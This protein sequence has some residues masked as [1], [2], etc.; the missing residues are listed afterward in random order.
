MRECF[1]IGGGNSVQESIDSG[2]WE[3]LKGKDIWSVNYAFLTMPY[4]PTRE[5]WL[6]LF[7]FKNNIDK[8]QNLY[9][10]GV[11]CYTKQNNKYSLI[12]EIKTY[13]VSRDI[14]DV[15]GKMYSGGMG[16]SGFFA[17]HLAVEEKYDRIFLFGYDFGSITNDKKTHYYQDKISVMS[18]GVGKPE[19]YR[20]QNSSIKKEV[21]DFEFFLKYPTKIYNVSPKSSI[22]CF[23]KLEYSDFIKKLNEVQEM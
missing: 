10:N 7:F 15:E 4:F 8:L 19:I 16:L 9:K 3:I 5:I 21:K 22:T 12:K 20:E 14:K 2:L 1:I 17:I 6:D 23:P 11:F 18:T 13:N